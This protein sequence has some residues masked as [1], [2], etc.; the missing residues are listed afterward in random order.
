M[1]KHGFGK[2]RLHELLK[3]Q[4]PGFTV[5]LKG[6]ISPLHTVLSMDIGM[7]YF[8]YIRYQKSIRVQVGINGDFSLSVRQHPEIAKAGTAWFCDVQMKPI[9]LPKVLAIVDC[10]CGKMGNEWVCQGP[11]NKKAL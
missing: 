2:Q 3:G 8:V 9:M 10:R 11:E 1:G 4:L 7:G 5:R 6:A